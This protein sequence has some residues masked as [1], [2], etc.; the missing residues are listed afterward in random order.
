ME[1]NGEGGKEKEEEEGGRR[2]MADY[3]YPDTNTLWQAE[4]R[5]LLTTQSHMTT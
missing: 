5:Q 4:T 3:T 1:R 2:R